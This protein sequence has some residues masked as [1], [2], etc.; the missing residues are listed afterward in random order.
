[1]NPGARHGTRLFNSLI[2]TVHLGYS[3][4]SSGAHNSLIMYG[5]TF[6]VYAWQT[7]KLL[8]H[9]ETIVPRQ[10]IVDEWHND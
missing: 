8:G 6:K 5:N 2:V 1:M 4:T 3:C 7:L 10:Y 9:S